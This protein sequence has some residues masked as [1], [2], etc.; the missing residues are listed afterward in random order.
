MNSNRFQSVQIILNI[1]LILVLLAVFFFERG[2]SPVNAAE[3]QAAVPGG[4]GYVMVPATAF[5]PESS[6]DGYRVFWG[7]LSVPEGSPNGYTI[8]N[9]PV[10]LP[11]GARLTGLTM[12]YTDTNNDSDTLGVDLMRK[13]L[14]SLSSGELVGLSIYSN[15]VDFG[16]YQSDTTAD[17]ARAIIDNSQYSY[18][19]KVYIYAAPVYLQ[20][21]AVRIDYAY[22]TALPAIRR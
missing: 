5:I 22:D 6:S 9:A 18:W 1:V 7:E 20:L 10:Y 16:V 2:S 13:P 8:F 3:S 19:L 14:P 15:L 21:Q 11:Q 17:P 4:P 12:Y